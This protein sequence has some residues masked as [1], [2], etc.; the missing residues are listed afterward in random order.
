MFEQIDATLNAAGV[1][2]VD[3]A[4]RRVQP[5]E[6]NDLIARLGLK[7]DLIADVTTSLVVETILR[8]LQTQPPTPRNF[9]TD[10]AFPVFIVLCDKLGVATVTRPSLPPVFPAPTSKRLSNREPRAFTD[11]AHDAASFATARRLSFR[12]KSRSK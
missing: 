1:S 9:E 8:A 11:F 5:L 4:A 3:V 2:L 10:A 6:F 7:S 12:R